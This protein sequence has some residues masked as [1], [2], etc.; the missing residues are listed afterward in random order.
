M[1]GIFCIDKPSGMTS[2]DVVAVMRKLAGEKKIGHAGTLDPMATGVLPLFLGRAT[3]AVSLLPCHDKAYIAS[4]RLGVTTDTGDITGN[5][6]A[7]CPVT[8]SRGQTEREIIA[9]KGEHQQLPPMMSA[10]RVGGKRLYELARKGET[11]ERTPR[12]ITIYDIRLT[13]CNERAGEYTMEVRCSKGTYIRTLCED[14]GNRLGCGA[15]MTS[16]RRTMAAG[17]SLDGCV[18]LDDARSLAAE[19]KL[20]TRLLTLESA[21]ASLPEAF[22]TEKQAVR[23]FNGGELALSRVTG[24]PAKNG[25][26]PCR[27]KTG[28]GKFIGLGFADDHEGSLKILLNR[29]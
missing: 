4:F 27:V 2:F 20:T 24:M 7:T 23:F 11:V 3:R 22:V 28:D 19:G 17:Y 29:V 26:G 13:G 15:A 14:I 1:D 12:P 5:V 21:F 9:C 25:N 6:T 8:A 16:L 10:V 18:T